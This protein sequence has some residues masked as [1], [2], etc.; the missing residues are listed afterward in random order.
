[1][2]DQVFYDYNLLSRR[3]A[4]SRQWWLIL[5]SLGLIAVLI[6]L[7]LAAATA[8]SYPP[9]G[10]V[11]DDHVDSPKHTFS[12]ESYRKGD[13]QN[14]G[15]KRC[16]W[17]VAPDKKTTYMLVSPGVLTPLYSV[18]IHISPDEQW[19]MWE[20]KLYHPANAY[21][22]FERS[23]GIHYREIGPP[24][25]SEQA[26]RF[27]NQQTRRRLNTDYDK[28]M[29]VSDWPSPGSRVRKL[30]LYGDSQMTPVTAPNDHS[31]AIS[32]YGDNERTHVDLWFCFYDLQEHRFYLDADLEKHN[33]G[34]VAPSHKKWSLTRR[35]SEPLA[36][37]RSSFR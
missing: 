16:V 37:P 4:R 19:I 24:I 30:A 13:Y 36:V 31:L 10:Y 21:G 26:W 1:M 11:L 20:Q 17:I 22:L 27:M 23:S 7:F 28:I 6:P 25:F 15:S 5:F 35:C 18:Q 3:H 8:L 9:Q 34:R 2:Y 14:E 32:L 29:R 33:K 12:V